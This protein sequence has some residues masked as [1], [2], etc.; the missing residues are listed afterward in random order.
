MMKQAIFAAGCFWGIEEDFARLPG[1]VET[2]VGYTG[3][4]LENPDYRAVC[5]GSTGHA[6]AVKITFDPE[7]IPYERLLEEFWSIHDPTQLN[8]QGPDVGSQYRSAIFYCDPQQREAGIRTL[9]ELEE[10]GRFQNRVTTEIVPASTFWEAEEYHQRYLAK[11]RG[12]M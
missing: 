3:G 8:R 12:E 9:D 6:E 1:V 2:R 4:H 10:S 7:V 11:Q 5:A